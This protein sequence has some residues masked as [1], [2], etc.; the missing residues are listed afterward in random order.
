VR[1]EL[2]RFLRSRRAR[3]QPADAGLPA[4]PRR[5]TPG[6]RREEVASL[7]GVG[8]SWYTWLE[9]GRDIQASA[10]VLERLALALRLT[11]AER[12][13]LFELAHDRPAP[14]AVTAPTAVSETLQRVLWAYPFPALVST[15][16]WDVLAWNAAAAVL[17]DFTLVPPEQRNLLRAMFSDPHRRALTAGWERDAR[18]A[19]ARFRRDAAR[20]ADRTSFD[21]LVAEL[22]ATSP[23]LARMWD[24]HDVAEVPEG[25]SALVHPALG[26]IELAYVALAHVEPDG[27]E[28]RVT[29]YSPQPGDS[30]ARAAVLFGAVTR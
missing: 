17:Y 1:D 20:A 26:V 14:T 25:T 23:E 13:Y 19:V 3:V 29:L 21:A 7:A 4:G 5:R 27:R 6:L 15:T 8:L 10:P 11:A 22:A 24:A 2:A 16:R 9:Q 18:A 28:L 30:A 12:A